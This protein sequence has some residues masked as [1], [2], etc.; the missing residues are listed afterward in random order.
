[1]RDRVLVLAA[2]AALSCAPEIA[3]AQSRWSYPRGERPN[4]LAPPAVLYSGE[5]APPLLV[6]AIVQR[7]DQANSGRAVVRLGSPPMER[8]V[9]GAGDRIGPYR[10]DRVQVDGLWVRLYALGTAR[11]L[12][13]P[14]AGLRSAA[15]GP[16]SE[17]TP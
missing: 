2:L 7:D 4:P 5:I 14:R 17:V 3:G 16:P 12:F 9:V 8:R 10:I 6:T 15:A 11:R 13:V 1:M